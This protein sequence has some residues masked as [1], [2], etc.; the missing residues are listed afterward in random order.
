MSKI[1]M[2]GGHPVPQEP[3]QDAQGEA[4]QPFYVGL[5]MVPEELARL[6]HAELDPADYTAV[7]VVGMNMTATGQAAPVDVGDGVPVNVPVF[8]V[9]GLLPYELPA[10]LGS[11]GQANIDKSTFPL[12]PVFR[13]VVRKDALIEPARKTAEEADRIRLSALLRQ[14]TA[15]MGPHVG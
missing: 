8:A 5:P 10:I 9:V 3:E 4:L 2:P 7:Q 12:P 13:V 6:A 14:S 1:L 11:D 15:T